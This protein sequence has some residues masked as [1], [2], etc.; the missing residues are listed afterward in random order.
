LAKLRPAFKKDGGTVTPGNSSGMNDGAS[1]G[2]GM[3][4]EKC[5]SLGLKP[6]VRI[7][8]MTAAGVDPRIMGIGPVPAINK[9]LAKAGLKLEDIDLFELN[10]AFAAQSLGVLKELGM[11]MGTELYKRVN[12]NGGAIAH[13][14]ALG[15]SGTRLLTTLIYEMK[16]RGAKYGIDSLCIGGGQGM[17]LIVENCD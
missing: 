3:S 10:E 4:E 1:A 14:H 12:V 15:N 8:T 2:V 9:A 16:R 11:D 7:V 5:K 6:L 13:G 17:A